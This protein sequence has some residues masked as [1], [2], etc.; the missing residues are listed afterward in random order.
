LPNETPTNLVPE[1]VSVSDA[2]RAASGRTSFPLPVR[3]R[4][5][6]EEHG[7]R[8]PGGLPNRF[9][10]PGGRPGIEQE[11]LRRRRKPRRERAREVG[12]RRI[13][14][15]YVAD[16]DEHEPRRRRE[17]ERFRCLADERYGAT[18][19]L[20]GER[21]VL[22]PVHDAKRGLEVRDRRGESPLRLENPRD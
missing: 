17:R 5:K 7:V 18:R 13:G 12:P 14:D 10:V 9:D 8:A 21:A 2:I 15:G 22:G 19:D 6:S 1:A 3:T 20:L 4:T 16:D 11:D